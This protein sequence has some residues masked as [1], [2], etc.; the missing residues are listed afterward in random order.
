M[1]RAK[2]TDYSLAVSPAEIRRYTMVAERAQ[3]S[4]SHLWER[5]GIAPGAVVADMAAGRPRCQSAWP[6]PWDPP[7]G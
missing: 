1:K 2:V 7:G 5:A 3:A 4:E 6:S